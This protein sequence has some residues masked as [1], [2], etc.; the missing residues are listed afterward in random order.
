M[1]ALGS[2]I[3]DLDTRAAWLVLPRFT[4]RPRKPVGDAGVCLTAPHE[5]IRVPVG[6]AEG[7]DYLPRVGAAFTAG[8][9]RR[10]S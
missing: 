9:R 4:L 5:I 3:A 7:I 1:E 2:H 8:G 6:V 10:R